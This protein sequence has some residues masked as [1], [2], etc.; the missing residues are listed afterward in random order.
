MHL[1]NVPVSI[2][3][4]KNICYTEKGKKIIVVVVLSGRTFGWVVEI[5]IKT[6]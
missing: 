2:M 1:I 6:K 5:K 3:I 4:D